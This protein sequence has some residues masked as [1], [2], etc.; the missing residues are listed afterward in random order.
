MAETNLAPSGGDHTSPRGGEKQPQKAT[1]KMMEGERRSFQDGD[2][3]VRNTGEVA[4]A[5]AQGM[6]RTAAEATR[7]I[8][9]TNRRASRDIAEHWRA[10][11]EPF[12][13][14]QMDLNRWF[15]EMWRLST[16]FAGFPALRGVR[17]FGA[18]SMFGMP[19]IDVKEGAGAYRLSMELPGLNREDIDLSIDNGALMIRAH[20][21]EE[22]EDP[23]AAHRISERHYGRIE[24]SFPLPGDVEP[25]RV[26]AAYQDGVLKVTLPKTAERE[27]TGPKIQIR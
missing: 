23:S 5:A 21:V 8:A 4:T 3:L 18:A 12:A 13:A 24:R 25:N 6:A 22:K 1:D 15:D 9:E 14:A 11:L 17:P 7:N 20:K 26:E 27:R 10:S 2:T 19:P 16:G